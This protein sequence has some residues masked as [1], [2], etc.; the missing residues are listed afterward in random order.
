MYDVYNYFF[1]KMVS[2]N[3][4]IVNVLVF[5]IDGEEFFFKVMECNMYYVIYLR[6]FGYFWDNCK[7]CL[8]VFL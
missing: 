1:L 5:G 3:I 8:C 2:L 6:C 7:E 4:D